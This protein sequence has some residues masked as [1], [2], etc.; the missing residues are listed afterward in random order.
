M[1]IYG[2]WIELVAKIYI[3]TSLVWWWLMIVI[4]FFD[5]IWRAR[6]TTPLN[7]IDMAL[8]LNL[9]TIVPVAWWLGGGYWSLTLLT[10]FLYSTFRFVRWVL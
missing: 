6:R 4:G 9:V 3:A 2:E 1:E 5:P 7:L 8:V 10:I